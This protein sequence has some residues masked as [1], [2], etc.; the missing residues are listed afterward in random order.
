MCVLLISVA[1]VFDVPNSH[2]LVADA[3]GAV[4][5][6]TTMTRELPSIGPYVGEMLTTVV[7]RSR[8]DDDDL[9]TVLREAG[10]SGAASTAPAMQSAKR[11]RT[12]IAA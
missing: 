3:A 5:E 11:R 10:A 12:F 1:V 9:L 2:S 6:I 8:R 7:D 4:P